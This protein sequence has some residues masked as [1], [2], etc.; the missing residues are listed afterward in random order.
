MGTYEKVRKRQTLCSASPPIGK[1]RLA[2]E[3]G[4]FV[5][6]GLTIE[7]GFRERGIEI[8]DARISNRDFGINN[9][10]DDEAI[11][12]G[13]ML[14]GRRGP[15]KPTRVFRHDIKKD[16]GINQYGRHS[17]IAGQRHYRI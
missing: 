16:V 1:E 8:F 11:P 15:P 4:G 14:D 3:K 2:I 9:W 10:I 5:W 6:N 13:G 17:V 7:H 12:V